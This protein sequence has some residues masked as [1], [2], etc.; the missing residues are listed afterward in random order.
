MKKNILAVC[1]REQEFACHLTD[2]L[3]LLMAKDGFPFE[4][5]VFTSPDKLKQFCKDSR[6]SFLLI[7]E[8]VYRLETDWEADQILI[9]EECGEGPPGLDT[10]NKYQSMTI[11]SAEL[12]K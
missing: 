10:V 5:Q 9:L 8:S 1:D 7:T 4:V 12:W 11:L 3:S 2:Y 6:V